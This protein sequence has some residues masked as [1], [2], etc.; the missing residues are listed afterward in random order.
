M[1]ENFIKIVIKTTLVI[2]LKF[3]I[4]KVKPFTYSTYKIFY[5]GLFLPASSTK[6][7][8]ALSPAFTR[9]PYKEFI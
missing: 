6:L 3:K 9:T 5:R 8:V 1:K 4:V 2:N 7:N